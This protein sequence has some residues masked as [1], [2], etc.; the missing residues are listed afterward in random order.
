LLRQKIFQIIAFIHHWL[1]KV[2]GHSLQSPYL[3]ELY[4]IKQK[5]DSD[6]SWIPSVEAIRNEMLSSHQE[7][8]VEDFGAGS[9]VLK[10]PIRLLKDVAKHSISTPKEA[11]LISKIIKFHDP[12]NIVELGTGLGITTLYLA[13]ICPNARI[14]TFE[15]ANDLANIAK[16]NFALDGKSQSITLVAGNI[17]E[18]FPTFL[19]NAP[20]IDF[21]FIDANHTQEATL[22]YYYAVLKNCHNETMIII[23]DIHWSEGMQLAWH[24]IVSQLDTTLTIDYYY[25]GLVL[26]NPKFKKQTWAF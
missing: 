10:S 11:E 14:T 2:D 15:G 8:N 20:K 3:F 17:N 25:F 26:L 6:M 5:P 1:S 13:N 21:I 18:T 7:L 22:A 9:A 16:Q 4:N 19:A 12:K 24:E 23:D